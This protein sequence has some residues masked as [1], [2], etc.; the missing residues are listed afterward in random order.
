MQDET[1][2]RFLGKN[3]KLVKTDDFVLKG[4]IEEVYEDSILFITHQATSLIS[5]DAIRE[6]IL[7]GDN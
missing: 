6:V 7:R 3:V 2:K 4:I 1:I 5:L